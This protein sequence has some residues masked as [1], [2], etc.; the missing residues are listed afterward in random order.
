MYLRPEISG[1]RNCHLFASRVV[2]RIRIQGLALLN[3]E[4]E[5]E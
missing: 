2:E 5:K 3:I 1:A 4:I